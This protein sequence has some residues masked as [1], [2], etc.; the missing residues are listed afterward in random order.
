ML[1]V[2]VGVVFLRSVWRFVHLKGIG[3]LGWYYY[4]PIS[5]NNTT[6]KRVTIVEAV[7][8]YANRSVFSISSPLSNTMSVE[9]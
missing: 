8:K 6:R 7:I 1:G 9:F 2:V 5:G 4:V 3:G